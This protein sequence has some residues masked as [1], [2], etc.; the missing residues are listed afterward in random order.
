MGEVISIS[1]SQLSNHVLTHLYNNQDSHIPYKRDFVVKYENSVFLSQYKE[2]G[3]TNYSP[4]ALIYDVRNGFGALGKYEY[5]DLESSKHLL[6]GY[7]V[8]RTG[9]KVG[10][11]SYQQALDKGVSHPGNLNSHNTRYWTD[12]NKLIY[13]PS[14]LNSLDSWEL[15]GEG[16]VVNKFTPNMQFINYNVGQEQFKEHE[17]EYVDKFRRLLEESDYFQGIQLFS[18]SDSS[19]SGFSSGYLSHIKDEFFNYTSNNKFNI[20]VWDFLKDG[21]LNYH[22]QLT[23]IKSM[24]EFS[25]DASLVFP[26]KPSSIMPMSMWEQS[27]LMSVAI[28]SL[29][30]LMNS[31]VSNMKEIE[32]RILADD[33]NRN[34]VN[35]VDIKELNDVLMSKLSLYNLDQNEIKIGFNKTTKHIFHNLSIVNDWDRDSITVPD[36]RFQ[37]T[38]Q[39]KNDLVD[40]KKI[41]SFPSHTLPYSK[42]TFNFLVDSS[43]KYDLDLF[44]KLLGSSR[45][46]DNI[47]GDKE[48]LVQDLHNLKSSYSNGPEFEDDSDSFDE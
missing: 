23:R 27:G 30:E 14:S 37:T 3:R 44:I 28:N 19:W 5:Y 36:S 31:K 20:W 8:I 43:I 9:E 22:E 47:V 1:C 48:E 33:F 42:A 17:D 16:K 2:N 25:K 32:S 7:E 26:L 45:P 6:D 46:I 11:G 34:I 35:S 13:R 41:D 29:W 39:S 21:K 12:Y 18:E 40:I 15:D 10:K 38:L 24:V 4:R